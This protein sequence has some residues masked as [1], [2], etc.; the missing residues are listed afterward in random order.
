MTFEVAYL[1]LEA[2]GAIPDGASNF[3]AP[4]PPRPK[5]KVKRMKRPHNLRLSCPNSKV[6]VKFLLRV[7]EQPWNFFFEMYVW[8][9]TTWLAE[10]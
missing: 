2:F 4:R 10:G 5:P 8:A 6:H 7:S 3:Y 1:T 9:P